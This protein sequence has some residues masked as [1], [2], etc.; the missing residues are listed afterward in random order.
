MPDFREL[1]AFRDEFLSRNRVGGTAA[2]QRRIDGG[3]PL[4]SEQPSVY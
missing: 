4:D 2:I 3:I 1:Q